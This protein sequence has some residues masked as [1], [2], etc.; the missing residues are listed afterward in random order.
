[1]LIGEGH[2][3]TFALFTGPRGNPTRRFWLM[4]A[5]NLFHFRHGQRCDHHRK[6]AD[7]NF[8]DESNAGGNGKTDVVVTGRLLVNKTQPIAPGHVFADD[9][10]L[11]P[12]AVEPG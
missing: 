7:Q 10:A 4:H 6:W 2:E 5:A 3:Q 1:M 12:L 8:R 11:C 9:H